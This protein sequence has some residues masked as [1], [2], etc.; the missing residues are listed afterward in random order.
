M[1]KEDR[2][3]KAIRECR[4]VEGY[5]AVTAAKVAREANIPIGS[6]YSLLNKLE[7]DGVIEVKQSVGMFGG[8]HIRGVKILKDSWG[9]NEFVY[10]SNIYGSN[11]AREVS[12]F[13]ENQKKVSTYLKGEKSE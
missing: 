9:D 2:L 13:N 3:L 1:K 10:P 4:M 12:N 7:R 6:I 11:R 5:F 8:L